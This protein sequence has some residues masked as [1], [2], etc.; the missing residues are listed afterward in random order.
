MGFI[1]GVGSMCGCICVNSVSLVDSSS[2]TSSARSPFW[3]CFVTLLWKQHQK[4]LVR[5]FAVEPPPPPPPPPL[6]CLAAPPR[7]VNVRPLPRV[8]FPHTQRWRAAHTALS[9]SHRPSVVP[10]V[11]QS[12]EASFLP[13][14]SAALLLRGSWGPGGFQARSRIKGSPC[15][16]KVPWDSLFLS[17]LK[18]VLYDPA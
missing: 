12:V 17:S 4:L 10:L 14:L 16:T 3:L 9:P 11:L 18:T 13:S 1:Y 8:S 6:R 2:T 7:L 5:R 15:T